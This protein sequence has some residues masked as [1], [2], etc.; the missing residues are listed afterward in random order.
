LHIDLPTLKL[1]LLF[2]W[3]LWLTIVFA[4]NAFEGLKRLRILPETWK[5]ASENFS[6]VAKATSVY[7]LPDWLVGLLFLGVIAWQGL[8]AVLFWAAFLNSASAGVPNIQAVNTAFGASLALWAAFMVAGEVFQAY[9]SQSNHMALF[10][11]QLVTL[12]SLHL[13]PNT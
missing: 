10:T 1:G 6:A 13:L 3:S 9:D 7:A 2:F 12:I 8:A 5:F 4:T 11:G